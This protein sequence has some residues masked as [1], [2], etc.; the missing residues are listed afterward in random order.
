MA[1]K[2]NTDCGFG[3]DYFKETVCIDTPRVYDS[4]SDRE[5]LE[6]IR[7]YI[8][9]DQQMMVDNARDVRIRNVCVI[10][11][12]TSLQELPFN[13][14]YYT[15]D[16][17]FYLE[18]ALEL[19]GGQGAPCI[20]VCGIAV[21]TKKAV[22]FGGEGGVKTFYSDM[23]R[24]NCDV[25]GSGN[26]PRVAVQVADPVALSAKLCECCHHH[27]H[28]GC[29]CGP[30]VIENLP[31]CIA[32][33]YGAF[34]LNPR[35]KMVFATV[36][37]FMIIQITRNVQVMIPAYDFCIPTKECSFSAGSETTPCDLFSK[38]DFPKDEFFPPRPPETP[39]CGCGCN[40]KPCH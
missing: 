39:D 4:C 26:Q 27:H 1:D 29:G 36:G 25:F 20:P 33:H 28:C 11:A 5:C 31:G 9:A 12:D 21:F 18:V 14:G 2:F 34:E 37:L 38:I 22:M 40:P 30:E 32:Q 13:K 35:G 15:M 17:T 19:L 24:C 8:P 23:D 16:I 3:R 10:T 6:D 7:V